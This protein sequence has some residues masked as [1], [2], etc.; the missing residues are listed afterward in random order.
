MVGVYLYGAAAGVLL[1]LPAMVAAG[2]WPVAPLAF[3]SLAC[4]VEF[5]M[6]GGRR[7]P[8]TATYSPS[9]WPASLILVL[10]L[11]ALLTFLTFGTA[12]LTVALQDRNAHATMAAILATLWVLLRWRR[13]IH[14]GEEPLSF[15]DDGDPEVQVTGFAPE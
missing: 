7:I 13:R 9:T 6:M 3:G 11:V 5:R 8:F 15:A 10:F 2:T 12:F 1:A 14:W 4:L